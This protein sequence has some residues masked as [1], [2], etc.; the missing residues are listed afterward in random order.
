M[1]TRVAFPQHS[2]LALADPDDRFPG[3]VVG[4]TYKSPEASSTVFYDAKPHVKIKGNTIDN[5]K[6]LNIA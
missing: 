6:I 3:S 2:D 5:Y 1:V 4:H